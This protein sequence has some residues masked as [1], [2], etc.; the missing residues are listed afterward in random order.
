MANWNNPTLTSNYATEV[1][2]QLAAKD[3]DAATMFVSAPT[4]QP[5]GSIKYNRSTNV[6]QESLSSVWTD[7]LIAVAGGGTGSS[8]ASGARTALGLGT[9]ATQASSAV[10]ITGGTITG[11]TSLTVAGNITPT[12][13]AARDIG[14]AATQFRYGFFTTGF[15]L[16][17][18]T[19]K[20]ITA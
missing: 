3:T 14:A 7:K 5:E 20:Y 17:V 9:I 6:F 16:P 15:K 8:T 1:L 11:I 4:N 2:Q 19:D 18:G 10:A 13:D 12:T